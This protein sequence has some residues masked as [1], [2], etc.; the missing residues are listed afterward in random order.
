[1]SDTNNGT[2][3]DVDTSNFDSSNLGLEEAR[4][5]FEQEKDR[6][7]TVETK[8]L[9]LLAI[10]TILITVLSSIGNIGQVI[11]S[12][13]ILFAILSVVQAFRTLRSFEYKR[14]F[15]QPH[16]IT[17]YISLSEKQFSFEVLMLYIESINHNKKVN[18]R[19]YN[20]YRWGLWLAIFAITLF[21]LLTVV[22]FIGSNFV[23]PKT[24]NSSQSLVN[25]LK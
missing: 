15:S 3:K 11:K 22:N 18:A 2:V 24:G 7:N 4:R 16:N 8:I 13:V 19:R 20:H 1:M 23:P 21:V 17:A 9:G 14:P 6:A 25:L 10:D 12:I 5:L